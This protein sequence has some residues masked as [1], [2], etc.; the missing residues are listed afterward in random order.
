RRFARFGVPTTVT[1]SPS[2]RQRAEVVSGSVRE[3][4]DR[5]S[6]RPGGGR[7]SEEC[8]FGGF[9]LAGTFLLVV[10][11]LGDFFGVA[12]VIEFEEAV[13]DLALGCWADGVAGLS[14][15]LVEAVVEPAHGFDAVLPP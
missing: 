10:K 7:T 5:H 8:P 1:A 11:A 13:E 6:R 14:A 15:G 12:F 4:R 9:G 2:R 3:C